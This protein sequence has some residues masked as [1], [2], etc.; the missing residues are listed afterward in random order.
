MMKPAI[1][2]K[3]SQNAAQLDSHGSETCE[4]RVCARAHDSSGVLRSRQY[5]YEDGSVVIQIKQTLYKLYKGQLAQQSDYFRRLF[6]GSGENVSGVMTRKRKNVDVDEVYVVRK[7]ITPHDFEQLLECTD[8]GLCVLEFNLDPS[9]PAELL[10]NHRLYAFSL[11]SFLNTVSVLRAASALSFTIPT[12][13]ARRALA[14]M[15]S[16][17]LDKVTDTPLEFASIAAQLATY[18][19]PGIRKRALY[20]LLRQ[21][22]FGQANLEPETEEKDDSDPYHITSALPRND[23]LLLVLAR[24]KVHQ[25]WISTIQNPQHRKGDCVH[26]TCTSFKRAQV[27]QVWEKNVERSPLFKLGL[28]DPLLALRKI[29]NLDWKSFGYCSDCISSLQT[30]CMDEQIRY[31]KLLDNWFRLLH[32]EDHDSVD[33]RESRNTNQLMRTPAVSSRSEAAASLPTPP[34][35]GQS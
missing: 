30:W 3:R 25:E 27:R 18:N 2:M 7:N 34:S 14:V 29:A 19:L 13:F 32:A 1:M 11:P 5:W 33:S 31:W 15:W 16:S 6:E 9:C 26:S 28:L 10:L 24:Q 21:E 8:K 20:E 17:D 12:E 23:L 4:C 35:T 22:D